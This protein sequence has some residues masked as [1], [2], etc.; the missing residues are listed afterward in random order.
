MEGT[1]FGV[2]STRVCICSSNTAYCGSVAASYLDNGV[3][4]S[5]PTRLQL[6]RGN[7][8]HGTLEPVETYGSL[9]TPKF[10]AG[11]TLRV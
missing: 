10:I 3:G 7:V 2:A 6:T 11:A 9:D 1:F 4:S 8:E 5:L